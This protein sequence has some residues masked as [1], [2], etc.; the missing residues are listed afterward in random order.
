MAR[1]IEVGTLKEID[2]KD[3]KWL[4]HKSGNPIEEADMIRRLMDEGELTQSEVASQLEISQGQVSKRLRLLGLL[5]EFLAL[6]RE[7]RLRPSTAYALSKLPP[8]KQ[9]EFMG[10]GKVFLKDVEAKRRKIAVTEELERIL[11]EPINLPKG[12]T[13]KL[14]ACPEVTEIK[15]SC[16]KCGGKL[17]LKDLVC[18]WEADGTPS[19]DDTFKSPYC[20]ACR[21]FWV[22]EPEQ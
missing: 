6:L 8:D 5:P 17:A 10:E 19:E 22:G 4:Y 12:L 7:G 14:V 16:P 13:T 11:E 20:A 18:A 2:S 21:L 1:E 9:K 15:G 3:V